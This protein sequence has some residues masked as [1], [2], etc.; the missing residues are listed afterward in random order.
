MFEQAL[1]TTNILA[2]DI[3]SDKAARREIKVLILPTM[4]AIETVNRN[5]N[6]T[7]AILHVTC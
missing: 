4:E 5:L 6:E 7:N 3:R 2:P 1:E